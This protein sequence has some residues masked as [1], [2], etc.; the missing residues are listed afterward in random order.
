MI[1]FVQ[2]LNENY[3]RKAFNNDVVTVYST[4]N[5]DAL[6]CDITIG[7]LQLRLY[8]NPGGQFFFNFRPY[9]SA[10]INTHNF[11][12]TLHTA[13]MGANPDT[14]LYNATD[15]TYL[16]HDVL[17][18]IGLEG[19][20]VETA[21]YNLAW[22]A[23]VEQ[24]GS[25]HNFNRADSLVLTPFR[26]DTAN[27]VYLKYWQGYPFDISLYCPAPMVYLSNETTL[28]SQEF[29]V[30]GIISRL[31]LSDGRTDETLETL[32]PFSDG[33]N[34]LRLGASA[35]AAAADKFIMLEK[36]PYTCGVYLK[37]LNKYGGYSYWLFEDT[38]TIDRS[39]RPLGE[40]DRSNANLGDTF[41]RAIQTGRESQDTIKVIAELL[42]DDERRIV[43]GILE[44]P[45][46]YLF[47]GQPYSRSSYR[48]W[49]EVSLK[50]GGSRIKNAKQPLTNFTFDLELPQRYTQTL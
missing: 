13:L 46:I 24:L 21:T 38:Y 15:G 7:T 11:E 39:T 31:A 16:A 6:Y 17:F 37:W 35:E 22:F 45:K 34:R 48:D 14:Y 4:T 44:S 40:L 1:T 12:D 20:A 29:D 43:E 9:V 25:H 33:Y 28:L 42:T 3:L 23:G 50:T 18:T 8:P 49:I 30:P 10:L 19:G 32:L 36:V 41:T 27:H 26:K 2:S 47:T 5:A